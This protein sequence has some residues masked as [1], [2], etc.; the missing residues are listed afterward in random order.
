MGR[1]APQPAAAHRLPRPHPGRV[2]TGLLRST[3]RPADGRS[4][5]TLSLRTRRGGSRTRWAANDVRAHKPGVKAFRHPAI[6]EV[7]LPFEKLTVDATGDHTL[8]VFTPQPGSPEHD[9][10]QLL[11]SWS[12]THGPDDALTPPKQA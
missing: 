7:I 4:L 5:N 12:A 9:A 2:R 6:G 1:L 3:P 11:A 10:I 8:T